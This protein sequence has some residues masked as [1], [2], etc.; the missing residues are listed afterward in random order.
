MVLSPLI[1]CFADETRY[2]GKVDIYDTS[3]QYTAHHYHD[4]TTGQED[5]IFEFSENGKV[6]FMKEV[7]AFTLLKIFEK[8]RV[9]V[10]LSNIKVRNPVQVEIFGFDRRV[11]LEKSVS[12]N[13]M[14]N[15]DAF[16]ISESVTNHIFWYNEKD[17]EI[18]VLDEN[19]ICEIK[20]KTPGNKS[21]SFA[22]NKN[23]EKANGATPG[24]AGIG[25]GRGLGKGVSPDSI[26]KS[27]Y[28]SSKVPN[29]KSAPSESTSADQN[30]QKGGFLKGG[31]S[32][33]GVLRTVMQNLA[34]IRYMYNGRL[35][36]VPDLKGIIITRFRVVSSGEVIYCKIIEATLIDSI[37]HKEIVNNIS[38]WSFEKM[39]QPNDTTEVIYPF[40]FSR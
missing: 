23:M 27:F 22:F 13:S 8:E 4:W 39:D 6:V 14:V 40:V 21:L 35:R 17:P 1:A 3:G 2:E 34:P 38:N 33:A 16:G 31:R 24:V 9:V 28:D 32:R 26:V 25:Y 19:D 37:M 15:S 7:P 5:G 18:T 11:L 20:I 30:R 29:Q 36:E 12:V 10:L